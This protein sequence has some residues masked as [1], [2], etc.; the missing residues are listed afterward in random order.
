MFEQFLSTV[1]AKDVLILAGVAIT[2]WAAARE[3]LRQAKAANRRVDKLETKFE[4]LNRE[5][6]EAKAGAQS[7]LAGERH[8]ID[9]H[10]RRSAEQQRQ[11][12][13]FYASEAKAALERVERLIKGDGGKGA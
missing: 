4:N 5:V 3:A 2:T 13:E 11:T 7:A 10:A 1:S 6:G 9:E 8:R 12:A